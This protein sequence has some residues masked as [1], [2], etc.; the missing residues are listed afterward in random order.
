MQKLFEGRV[1]Q[2]R[3]LSTR[4]AD[5]V[6]WVEKLMLHGAIMDEGEVIDN[7]GRADSSVS[8]AMA[9]GMEEPPAVAA[10][11]YNYTLAPHVWELNYA[12]VRLYRA[13]RTPAAWRTPCCAGQPRAASWRGGVVCRMTRPS[14][15]TSPRDSPSGISPRATS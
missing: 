11:G 9:T 1:W 12:D 5:R 8:R 4:D 3:C 2:L 10:N 7:V 14:G 6:Y 15:T 13:L